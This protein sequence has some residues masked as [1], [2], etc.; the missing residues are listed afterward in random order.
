[1]PTL[2]KKTEGFTDSAVSELPK[3]A[4][5]FYLMR[6]MTSASLVILFQVCYNMS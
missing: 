4:A 1:M 2:S 3:M 5:P 6:T